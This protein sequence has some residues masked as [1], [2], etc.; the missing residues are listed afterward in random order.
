MLMMMMKGAGNTDI[1]QLISFPV[2][3]TFSGKPTVS[4]KQ[5]W[6]KPVVDAQPWRL[7]KTSQWRL[8]FS[9]LAVLVKG[10]GTAQHSPHQSKAE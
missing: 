3:D 8:P 9:L 10:D 1:C 4:L 2:K 6:V 7:G 5:A